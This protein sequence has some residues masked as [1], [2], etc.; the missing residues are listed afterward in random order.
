MIPYETPCKPW[1]VAG[2]DIFSMNINMILC[3][4]DYYRKLPIVKEVDGLS[5]EDLIRA[6][7]IV[8]TKFGLP[9]KT[10]FRCR[11]ELHIRPI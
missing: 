7:K 1:E 5:A 2:A 4:V 10:S 3:I 9:K 8:F 11:H 6:A